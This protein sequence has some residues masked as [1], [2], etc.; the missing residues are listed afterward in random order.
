MAIELE[1]NRFLIQRGRKRRVISGKSVG[2]PSGD[3]KQMRPESP[4]H[5]LLLP[6]EQRQKLAVAFFL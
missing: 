5:L 2:A 3:A 4:P 1:S 6:L